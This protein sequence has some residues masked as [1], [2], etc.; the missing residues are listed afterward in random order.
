M[1]LQAYHEPWEKLK[2]PLPDA[3]K[4]GFKPALIFDTLDA[5]SLPSDSFYNREI[6]AGFMM[7]MRVVLNRDSF[8][9]RGYRENFMRL[10]LTFL[11]FFSVFSWAEDYK[12]YQR[13]KYLCTN[14]SEKEYKR[15]PED[16]DNQYFYYSCLVIQGRDSEGLPHL[17]ILADHHSHLLA[18]DFLA[19]YLQTD[20]R[21]E[22]PL[23]HVTVDEAIKYRMRTQAIIKLMPYYPEP[24]PFIERARQ[25]EL[26]SAYHLPHLYL[27]KYEL[28]ATG[29]YR[30]RLLQ[31]PSYQGDRNKETYPKYNS[32]T[33]DSLNNIIRYAGECASQ[34][35]KDHFNLDRYQATVKSCRLMKEMALTMLPLEEKR[36]G[37]LRQPHCEDLN[38]TNCPEYYEH[39]QAI[40]NLNSGYLKEYEK[41]FSSLP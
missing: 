3:R 29:D 40:K 26:K 13:G 23:T 39:H 9:L 31:S 27:L 19:N 1:K 14:E 36:Q 16:L 24:Y 25:I 10:L 32:Y 35:Q 12:E 30:K 18:S 33:R 4:A 34:P 22:Y 20:G 21:L 38:E 41:L 11:V 17:Y 2:S 15:E 5:I 7:L 8:R 37:V 28:G 6:P